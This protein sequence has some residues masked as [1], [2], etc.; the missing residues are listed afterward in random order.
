MPELEGVLVVNA[1]IF[2]IGVLGVLTR[3]NAV[4]ILMSLELM[5]NAVSLNM[6]AFAVYGAR[7][8]R[9]LHGHR[10]CAIHHCDRPPRKWRWPWALWFGRSAAGR[11]QT[12]TK[13]IFSSGSGDATPRSGAPASGGRSSRCSG[14]E[15][16]WILPAIPACA[17]LVMFLFGR[18]LPRQGDWLSNHRD[19][20][21]LRAVFLRAGIAPGLVQRGAGRDR[22]YGIRLAS[23]SATSRCGSG[24]RWIRSR[25]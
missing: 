18:L 17:F 12:S 10:L 15:H 25:W 5:L 20:F 8:V 6:V 23:R 13:S 2:A 7:G 9:E 19:R 21:G 4:L 1:I 14:F 22:Q 16:A 11:R 3:R 24:S